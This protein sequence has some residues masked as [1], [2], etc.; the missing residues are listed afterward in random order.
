MR[1]A[2]SRHQAPRSAAIQDHPL[3]KKHWQKIPPPRDV[4]IAEDFWTGRTE[5]TQAQYES[6]MGDNPTDPDRVP[7]LAGGIVRDPGHPVVL[8]T[9]GM[10]REFC[11][12]VAEKT[13][14]NVHLPTGE[15]WG[16]AARAGGDGLSA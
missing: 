2:V 11:R 4:T 15:Q 6:V 8:T 12:K 9:C 16:Y 7:R 1:D 13:G 14:E 10:A 3:R 5:A